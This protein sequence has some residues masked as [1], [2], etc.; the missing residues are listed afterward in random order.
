MPNP[1]C[2][3]AKLEERV[4][5]MQQDICCLDD[6]VKKSLSEIVETLQ[7]MQRESAK[8]KGF[9]GGAVFVVGAL[10]TV[11]VSIFHKFFNL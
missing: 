8:Q 1:E 10:S 11:L 4:S 3:L 5:N 6:D 2:R 9:I 7:D